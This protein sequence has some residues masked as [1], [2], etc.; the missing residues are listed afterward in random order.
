MADV[1]DGIANGFTERGP[2]NFAVIIVDILDFGSYFYITFCTPDRSDVWYVVASI[3]QAALKYIRVKNTSWRSP[4]GDG[5]T[6]RGGGPVGEAASSTGGRVGGRA[7]A[8]SS[9]VGPRELSNS[10]EDDLEAGRRKKKE[11]GTEDGGEFAQG[12]NVV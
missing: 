9:L 1:V 12:A 3:I 8:E 6:G 10:R 11:N 2:L 5:E 4:P 7:G